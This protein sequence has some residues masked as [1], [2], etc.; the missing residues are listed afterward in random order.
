[1]SVNTLAQQLALVREAI[2]AV[3]KSQS[4]MIDG[5]QYTRAN[6]NALLAYEKSLLNRISRSRGRTTIKAINLSSIS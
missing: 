3:L 6:L 2:T 1:M 5:I 4:Y